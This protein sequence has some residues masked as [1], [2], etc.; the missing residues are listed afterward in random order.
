V[1]N[2]DPKDAM[3]RDMQKEME[4]LRSLLAENG[5]DQVYFI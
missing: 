1:I 5:S 3:L 4:R 2:E